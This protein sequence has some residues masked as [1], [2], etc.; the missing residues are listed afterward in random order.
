MCLCIIL[1]LNS[2]KTDLRVEV[3]DQTFHELT[4]DGHLSG[5]KRE[6]FGQFVVRRQDDP[7]SRRVVLRSPCSSKYLLDVQNSQINKFTV[8]VHLRSLKILFP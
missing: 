6:V 3:V 8:D 7:M 2:H 4:L 5:E 1:L